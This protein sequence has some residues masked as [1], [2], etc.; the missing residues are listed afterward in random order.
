M[1]IGVDQVYLLIYTVQVVRY[2]VDQQV[3]RS[4]CKSTKSTRS[5][6]LVRNGL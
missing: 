2:L 6:T 5:F 1:E 4:T 3:N